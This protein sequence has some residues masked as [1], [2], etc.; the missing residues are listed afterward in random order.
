MDRRFIS[1]VFLN[2]GHAFDHLFMLIFPAVIVVMARDPAS[3][4]IVGSYGDAL[5]LALGGFIAFGAC[6]IPAGW[7]GDRWSR[8]GMMIIFFI[9]IG[10]ASVITGF[11]QNAFQIAVAL[12]AIGV[13]AAIYH[14]IGIAT[15]VGGRKD[16]GRALGINGVAGNMGVAFAALVA[17]GFADLVSWRAAFIIPGLLSIATGIAYAIWAPKLERSKGGRPGAKSNILIGDLASPALFRRLFIILMAATIFGGL[18]FNATTISMPKVFEERLTDLT[19][20]SYGI[21]ILVAIVYVLAAM[22][23]LIVGYLIDRHALRSIFIAIAVTQVPL[24]FLAGWLEGYAMFIVAI[25]MMFV[26]FGQIPIND[27]MVARYTDDAWRSRVYALRYVVSFGA[28]ACAVPLVAF[29][30]DGAGGFESLF[31]VLAIFA[32]GTM[33]A[34]IA[35]PSLSSQRSVPAS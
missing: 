25:A 3:A 26:I 20:T 17:T 34:A 29:I 12:T 18:V 28:S 23:Q 2:I 9:G 24:L 32:F 10:A 22:A 15:L 21:G 5:S 19:Q 4:L 14:P 16:L 1:D 13:F 35:F 6:S 27:A 30:H 33:L 31:Q 8:H 7:L 11:A